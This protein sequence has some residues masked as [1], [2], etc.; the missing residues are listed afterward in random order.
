MSYF[1]WV[2]NKTCQQWDLERVDRELNK[3]MI[4]AAKRVR[5]ARKKYKC[6]LRTAAYAAALERLQAAYSIRGLFP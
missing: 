1:E 6:N 2:Q 4:Q 3:H 5:D